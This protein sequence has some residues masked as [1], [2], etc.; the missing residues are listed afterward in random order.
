MWCYS[1]RM[2]FKMSFPEPCGIHV[3]RMVAHKA[4]SQV[5]AA[6]HAT[7]MKSCV[8]YSIIYNTIGV[9]SKMCSWDRNSF[10]KDYKTNRT[11]L[12]TKRHQSD[13]I[14]CKE[15]KK[16]YIQTCTF[17]HLSVPTKGGATIQ[18]HTRFC[19]F[20]SIISKTSIPWIE[21]LIWMCH[22]LAHIEHM[23]IAMIFQNRWHE[24]P[25]CPETALGKIIL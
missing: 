20:Y 13:K 21:F 12:N 18:T 2:A 1:A 24:R 14:T 23:A 5:H 19:F 7:R 6:S 16:M 9:S 3:G 10:F 17:R 25:P 4:F 22:A 11:K 15:Y 8:C